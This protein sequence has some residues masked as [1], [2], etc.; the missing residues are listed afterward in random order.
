MHTT[1][2]ADQLTLNFEKQRKVTRERGHHKH[3][4]RSVTCIQ[5][6][7]DEAIRYICGMRFTHLMLSNTASKIWLRNCERLKAGYLTH[8]GKLD[9]ISSCKYIRSFSVFI[10]L[11]LRTSRGRQ[12]A[13]CIFRTFRLRTTQSFRIMFLEG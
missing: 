6:K 12:N 5:L 7:S 2:G 1:R 13:N 4:C 9:L 11:T 8:R 10:N 3:S